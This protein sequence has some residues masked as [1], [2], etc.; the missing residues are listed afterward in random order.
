MLALRTDPLAFLMSAAA[1]GGIAYRRIG[2]YRAYLLNDPEDVREL[3]LNHHKSSI[4]GP[5]LQRSK[6]LLGEGLVTGDGEHHLRQRRLLQPFFIVSACCATCRRWSAVP[7]AAWRAF[8][9]MPDAGPAPRDDA[10]GAFDRWPGAV[11]R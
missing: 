6:E 3:L 10:A 2:S 4:K 11:R 9:I 8:R 1:D 7:S 5:L